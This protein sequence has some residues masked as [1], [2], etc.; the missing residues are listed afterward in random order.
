MAISEQDVR[1]VA[2]LARLALSDEQVTTLQHEL[3]SILGHIDEIQKLD[4][5]DVKPTAH[6]LDVV[7]VT[8]A[9]RA[10]AWSDTG[11]GTCER[12]GIGGRRIRHPAHRRR[13]GRRV[14]AVSDGTIDLS[15]LTAREVRDG[16]AE[17]A[18]LRS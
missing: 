2:T 18:L 1:H 9:G 11:A 17:Q 10:K 13:R 16:I 5:G 4:L 15:A 8:R 7:N 3:S 12:A 14:V 6:P